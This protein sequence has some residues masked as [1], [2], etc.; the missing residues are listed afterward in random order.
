MS[1]SP[2][3][4]TAGSVTICDE[5]GSTNS[6][7]I[8]IEY[9]KFV[10]GLAERRDPSTFSNRSCSHALS[11]LRCVFDISEKEVDIF[12]GALAPLV[13]NDEDLLK[14]AEKFLAVKKGKIRILL[15][16][17]VPSSRVN[18]TA[19]FLNFVSKFPNICQ[20]KIVND[21]H[22]FK[23]S[24]THF[25]VADSSAYRIELDISQ[26][27][28]ICSLEDKAFASQLNGIFNTAW[29]TKVTDLPIPQ[30]N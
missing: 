20:V 14:S 21:D 12:S 24:K 3:V 10:R 27:T 30:Q 13:Y 9:D 16:N 8:D 11:I 17:N 28:A 6:C 4:S 22:G 26:H 25:L 23:N 7:E 19:D 15:Q 2:D 1:N 5:S 18:N 29:N